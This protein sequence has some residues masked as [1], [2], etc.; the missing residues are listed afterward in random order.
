L[1]VSNQAGF[2]PEDQPAT[3]SDFLVCE[4]R[5][6]LHAKLWFLEFDWLSEGAISGSVGLAYTLKDKKLPIRTSKY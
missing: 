3:V 1:I 6:L 5:L 4:R 2:L